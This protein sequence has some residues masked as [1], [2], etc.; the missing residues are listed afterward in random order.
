[1]EDQAF[2]PSY[3]LAPPTPLSPALPSWSASCL[4]FSLFHSILSGGSIEGFIENQ[5]FSPSYSILSGGR[6]AGQ[7]LLYGG[8]GFRGHWGIPTGCRPPTLP[9]PVAAAGKNH[10]KD[11]ITPLLPTGIGKRYSQTISNLGH[12][13]L[14]RRCELAL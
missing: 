1:M 13:A 10:L 9:L 4:P 2:S 5:A 12:G 6:G 3:D 14:L 11:E 8:G 7:Y